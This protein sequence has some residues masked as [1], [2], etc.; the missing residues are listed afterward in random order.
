MP[1]ARDLGRDLVTPRLDARASR[2]AR[3]IVNARTGQCAL[4]TAVGS[5]VLRRA[6]KRKRRHGNG[7]SEPAES[8]ARP[9]E[10]NRRA[11]VYFSPP[12]LFNEPMDTMPSMRWTKRLR[13]RWPF[14]D[15]P[16]SSPEEQPA[17]AAALAEQHATQLE[18]KTATRPMPCA[19]CR[20]VRR[21][22]HQ[23]ARGPHPN[24]LGCAR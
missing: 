4:S 14:L 3:R 12:Y 17:D 24:A 23:G 8:L 19:R 9:Q 1:A 13:Y 10:V 6:C 7:G 2:L 18:S 11:R 21:N 16:L 5:T 22:P 20:G 15:G